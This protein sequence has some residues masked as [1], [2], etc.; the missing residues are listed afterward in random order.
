MQSASTRRVCCTPKLSYSSRFNPAIWLLRGIHP[1][2][3]RILCSRPS[4]DSEE[5]GPGGHET[6]GKN[7]SILLPGTGG[8]VHGCCDPPKKHFAMNTYGVAGSGITL[9]C[10]VRLISPNGKN[11]APKG[12]NSVGRSKTTNLCCTSASLSARVARDVACFR[13]CWSLWGPEISF[14]LL[15]PQ[16]FHLF[17]DPCN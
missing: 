12:Q 1:V 3:L 13:M 8:V 11:Q 4:H 2:V 5:S 16:L 6:G 7:L 10:L 17:H 14:I 15:I 9:F